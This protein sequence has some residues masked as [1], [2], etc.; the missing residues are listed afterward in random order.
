M[1]E[2][3]DYIAKILFEANKANMEKLLQEAIDTR[4]E[5]RE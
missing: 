4:L 5:K 2:T 3:G 1:E